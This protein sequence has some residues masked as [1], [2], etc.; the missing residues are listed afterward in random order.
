MKKASLWLAL[1]SILFAIL[2]ILSM[3]AAGAIANML[4]C[5]LDESGTS[6]CPTAIGDMG[7][8]LSLMGLLGWFVFYTVP[9]GFLG[10]LIALVLFVVSLFLGRKK[11]RGTLPQN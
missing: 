7:E 6:S 9:L 2:P 11:E 5:S 3:L 1:L 4:D 10:L 8:L